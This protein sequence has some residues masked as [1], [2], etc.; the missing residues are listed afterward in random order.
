MIEP[1]LREK[2]EVVANAEEVINT[3]MALSV[4]LRPFLLEYMLGITL[5]G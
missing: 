4:S 2:A 1:A 3:V 5:L